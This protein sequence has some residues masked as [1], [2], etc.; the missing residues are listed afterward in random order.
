MGRRRWPVAVPPF[1]LAFLASAAAVPREASALLPSAEVASRRPAA[2]PPKLY[3]G[4][5]EAKTALEGNQA[6]PLALASDDFDE[7]G[8][9]DLVSAYATGASGLLVIHRGNPDVIHP[10]APGA[11]ERALLDGRAKGD[12]P[13]SFLAP[14][15]I[16]PVPGSPD[17]IAAGDFDADGHADV[18]LAAK[19]GTALWLLKGD[20]HGGFASPRSR[21]LAAT[22]TAMEAG[23]VN[24]ADGLFDVVVGVTG[25][26]GAA[27]LVFE[28]PDGAFGAEP[29]RFELPGVATAIT[30]DDFD[31]DFVGD[32]V[33]VGASVETL[34][35]GRDRRLTADATGRASVHRPAVESVDPRSPLGER[36]ALRVAKSRPAAL[37]DHAQAVLRM[38]LGKDAVDDLVVLRDGETQPSVLVTA[39]AHSFIVNATGPEHDCDTS[40][41]VCG[42]DA[43]PATPACDAGGG[44]TLN[45]ALDQANASV[46]ADE[47][48]FGLDNATI[49][50]P[51]VGITDPVTIDGTGTGTEIRGNGFTVGGNG[52]ST[53][54]GLVINGG[55]GITITASGGGSRIE[56]NWIGPSRS[57][58]DPVPGTVG[59]VLIDH[60]SGNVVGGTDA[61]ARNVISGISGS[62]VRILGGSDN[63]VQ[64]NYIGTDAAGT[65]SLSS[66][67]GV[68]IEGSSSNVVG[69]ASVAARNLISANGGQVR[70]CCEA[71]ATANRIQGNWIGFDATGTKAFFGGNSD[72]VVVTGSGHTLGGTSFATRNVIAGY[73]S[74]VSVLGSDD[75]IQGNFIGLDAAGVHRVGAVRGVVIQVGSGANLIGGTVPG[76]RNVIAGNNFD[77]VLGG[78]GSKVQG[79][80]IGRD[81]S[82][83]Q[84]IFGFSGGGGI[85]APGDGSPAN[86][87]FT[88]SGTRE[89]PQVVSSISV[90]G[91]FVQPTPVVIQGNFIGT[92][93]DGEAVALYGGGIGI[94][95]ASGVLIGGP[96][97]GEGN[98]I[99]NAYGPAIGIGSPP[100]RR[101]RI[102]RNTIGVSASGSVSLGSGGIDLHPPG[103]LSGVTP[104]DVIFTAPT[105]IAV[106][107]GQSGSTEA[108]VP[109]H[110]AIDEDVGPN[111]LQNFPELTRADPGSGVVEG[112]LES[113][114]GTAYTIEVFAK[115]SCGGLGYGNGGRFLAA[116]NTTTDDR[117]IA[118]FLAQAAVTTGEFVTATATDAEGNTSEFSRCLKADGTI[119]PVPPP[120]LRF[121]TTPGSATADTDF[122]SQSGA[123][124]FPEGSSLDRV[125]RVPVIGD[126]AAEADERFFV[127][128]SPN[129]A[130]TSAPLAT[131]TI[132]DDDSATYLDVDGN[133]LTVS[134]ADA[135]V[136]EG[137]S[138]ASSAAF[139]VTLSGMSSRTV[140]ISYATADVTASVTSDYDAVSGTLTFPPGTLR[141]TVSVPV[142][143]D[144]DV[145][146]DET[147]TLSLGPP[148]NAGLGRGQAVGVI[149]DDD[150]SGAPAVVMDDVTT[151]EYSTSLT[152]R[153]A[154]PATQTVT[155]DFSAA[156]GTAEKGIDFGRRPG[157]L[158]FPPGTTT[159]T[160]LV[161]IISDRLHEDD[162]TFFIDLS[163]PVN[164]TIPRA[165]A[166][167]LILDDDLA[168]VVSV[169]DLRVLE[170]DEGTNDAAV[171]VTLSAPSGLPVT[172][173]F[174]TAD[175]SAEAG[176]DYTP[177]SGTLVFP[178]GTAS[179]TITIPIVGDV[180]AEAEEAFTVAI[181][182]A[183]DASVAPATAAVTIV[184]DESRWQTLSDGPASLSAIAFNGKAYVAV[185]S[186]GEIWRSL[187]GYTWTRRFNPDPTFSRLGGITWGAGQFVAVGEWGDNF[188]PGAVLTSPN[189]RHWTLRVVG[190]DDIDGPSGLSGVAYGNGRYVAVGGVVIT[191]PDAVTWTQVSG[192]NLQL[193]AVAFGAGVFVATAVNG[194]M[195]RSTDGSSWTPVSLPP[196][197]TLLRGIAY[198]GTQFVAAGPLNAMLTSP[199][200]VTWV[201]RAAP[202]GGYVGVAASPGLIVAVGGDK[203]ITS[204]DGIVWTPG[205][206]VTSTPGFSP[207]QLAVTFGTRFVS[208]GSQGAIYTSEAGT[209]QWEKRTLEASHYLVGVASSGSVDCAVGYTGSVMR[210]T[211]G[212][213]WTNQ[214]DPPL[215]PNR[216]LYAVARGAGTFVALT[217][218]PG[219][220]TSPDC[221]TWIDRGSAGLDPTALY[222]NVTHGNGLFVAVG[223]K[224]FPV[225]IPVVA[226]SR[227]GV[228][229]TPANQGIPADG[230]A[231]L[232][233]AIAYGNGMFVVIGH[234]PYT[235]EL[236]SLSSTDGLTWTMRPVPSDRMIQR[237]GLAFHDGTFVA[238]ASQLWSSEDGVNWTAR[239]GDPANLHGGDM[240]RFQTVG[241][242][243][244]GFVATDFYG[245]TATSPDG[246]TWAVDPTPLG[247]FINAIGYSKVGHRLIGVGASFVV[248]FPPS[249]ALPGSV[250]LAVR[251]SD[252]PD[253]V[254]AGQSL[255]YAIGVMNL[256]PVDATS[257]LVEDTLPAGVAFVSAGGAGWNC[258]EA[259]G[260]VTCSRTVLA[261]G[262][263][264]PIEVRVNAPPGEGTLVNTVRVSAFESDTETANDTSM[265][266]TT[267]VAPQSADLWVGQATDAPIVGPRQ[268]FTYTITAA[269]DGPS[270][271]SGATVTDNFPAT[272]ASVAW[273]CTATAGSSC[274]PSGSGNIADAP[275]LASGGR[276]TYVATVVVGTGAS[277][278]IVNTAT[279]TAPAGIADPYSTNDAATTSTE[280]EAPI[281]ADGFETGDL[282]AW[283]TSS[284]DA[285]DLSVDGA[286]AMAGTSYGLSA[287]VN[288]VAGLY[289]EDG[290]PNDEDRYRARFYLDPGTF[291]PGEANDSFRAR[292]FLAFEEA[293]DR[294]L[295]AVVLK[296]QSGIYS[297]G[298]R[299]RLDDGSQADTGFFPISS[300]PHVVEI[301]WTRAATAAVHDGT[302]ALW[303]DGESKASL[304][305]LATSVSAVDFAR[306]G[307][308]S[309]KPGASGTVFLD[310]FE[311]RR[312][313]YI[314]PEP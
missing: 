6:R 188:Q 214:T 126:V 103:F 60:S 84:E 220:L 108:L 101:N 182:P 105:A 117:G 163:N 132:L 16:L 11:R 212:T 279:V 156:S 223:Y 304:T 181:G 240:L 155:V 302:F 147:F 66:T 4:P 278:A 208:V 234:V 56:G 277:G 148:T 118:T 303:V 59:G 292:V 152:V 225:Y 2:G 21:E 129:G 179:Q 296:R 272:V 309:I 164:A 100:A 98:V 52:P 99:A 25:A 63:V 312:L 193:N 48:D 275:A 253:P 198:T 171:T 46:G 161:N 15:R 195:S 286:A 34:V 306:L 158:T 122:V 294:R 64:G 308:M 222:T 95:G 19:G 124:T 190:T 109:V 178:P 199:D 177:V 110:L 31:G 151:A 62:A 153:L 267:V 35:H 297:L 284:A 301:A 169:R 243:P 205:S 42:I 14:G 283:T 53:I 289:A 174:A 206:F 176:A 185:G 291:D 74:A 7:D 273:T 305:A 280:I 237:A 310:E 262:P 49:A 192:K 203:V 79:N 159:Q 107:E 106:S 33:A 83:D 12:P 186:L 170:G 137:N 189:G 41:D 224:I 22:V 40:D 247:R 218:T 268:S 73:A 250:N 202:Q 58:K 127:A 81:A 157:T 5:Q 120:S 82:G 167:V 236:F 131:V 76:A 39:P 232:P 288:D 97:P 266:Q 123:L 9:P 10:N 210:S 45:A 166:Q 257:V 47:I 209:T 314:G 32:F 65:T 38:R 256:G 54:R 138:G 90:W 197:V 258:G 251:Q 78:L 290:S 102:Q 168:P 259:G 37:A 261:R 13:S 263:A 3:E 313:S 216:T 299:V 113:R 231:R 130:T 162:E 1:L 230:V 298:A 271:A 149:L 242:S 191:S 293:P 252:S 70:I 23:E 69:G 24:R 276:A 86:G 187:D 55:Y 89:A 281:F 204:P 211:D 61:A 219:V 244:D 17:F 57:G 142:H 43:D 165:R 67:L 8:V 141:Q 128:L 18:V 133:P 68:S 238:L 184:D 135:E 27:A 172:V 295:I 115:A 249:T 26:G 254:P 207:S 264:P 30:I 239:Y 71:D 270:A 112:V 175:G 119:L 217:S 75:K 221:A 143:G 88:I 144:L 265:E 80:Y 311:S 104:N 307:V 227:D 183:S 136:I 134:V 160:F 50:G 139:T 44:C 146:A 274:T 215:S 87:N 241:A 36:A 91:A 154:H 235:D 121:W 145:E 285:G 150:G 269:N 287:A 245:R 92:S 260:V 85:F 29:E 248:A 114:P 282:S 255:T 94:G 125:I 180:A 173:G 228:T 28:A 201:K 213:I 111:D 140:T 51:D 194:T 233:D 93:H 96:N 196:G 72:S 116:I 246:H 200:G 229:W 20:G 226:T 300:G 77:V